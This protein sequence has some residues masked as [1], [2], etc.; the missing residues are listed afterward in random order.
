MKI[1]SYSSVWE[2]WLE[3]QGALGAFL[4]RKTHD[5]QLTEDILHD[6]L[7]K[8]HKAC[9]NNTEILNVRSWL[10]Q[11][12]SNTLVDH[13]KKQK[14]KVVSAS[15]EIEW[16]EDLYKELAVF[17]EPL[18]DLL[19]EKYSLPLKMSDLEGKKQGDIANQLN[20]SVTATKSRVQRGR[21]LL[22]AKIQTCFNLKVC[23]DNGLVSFEIKEDCKPLQSSIEKKV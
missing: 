5:P 17:V 7:L 13:I 11:I 19:P 4:L 21:K 15:P 8:I 22:M 1:V 2:L 10:F 9:C 12:A 18:I 20:L 23:Q 6:V 16:E 14:T 3:Y